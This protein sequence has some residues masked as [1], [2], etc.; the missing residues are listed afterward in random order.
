MQS[1]TRLFE[2][3]ELTLL[4]C[5]VFTNAVSYICK[6]ALDNKALR[7]IDAVTTCVCE[8][9]LFEELTLPVFIIE[10]QKK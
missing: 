9:V 4:S 2:Q 7:H 6:V 5:A 1:V 10:A 8:H 3:S